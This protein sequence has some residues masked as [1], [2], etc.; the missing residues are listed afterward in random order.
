MSD[1]RK[2]LDAM[3]G[4][5]A[6]QRYDGDLATELLTPPARRRSSMRLLMAGSLV[7]GLAA[8]MVLWIGMRPGAAI[9]R[10]P[11]FPVAIAT[12][13]TLEDEALAPVTELAT[14]PSFPEDVPLVPSDGS[15][16]FGSMPT[17][18]SLDF[19]FSDTEISKEST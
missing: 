11:A 14:L 9:P 4:E 10:P 2:Q 8:A 5:Y 12:T 18:P 7:T 19:T 13:Q 1:L 3:R 16:E 15:I 6:A 17:M